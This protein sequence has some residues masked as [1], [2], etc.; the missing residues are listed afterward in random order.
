MAAYQPSGVKVQAKFDHSA[1]EDLMRT[2]ARGRAADRA[3]VDTLPPTAGRAEGYL[4]RT[5]AHELPRRVDDKSF[6]HAAFEAS[7]PKMHGYN[8]RELTEDAPLP[9]PSQDF[10]P[11]IASA[12]GTLGCPLDAATREDNFDAYG[13]CYSDLRS[14]YQPDVQHHVRP[15]VERTLDQV[16]AERE[17]TGKV[18]PTA[19][20]RKFVAVAEE[21]DSLPAKSTTS[22]LAAS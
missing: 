18:Y 4:A 5:A 15:H 20:G 22:R 3:D 10:E 1:F 11:Y 9:T 6:D 8:L 16:L 12:Y 17:R 19:A 2:R 14:A 21:Q 13:T 7:R